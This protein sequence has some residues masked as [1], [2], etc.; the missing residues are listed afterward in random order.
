M[1]QQDKKQSKTVKPFTPQEVE[2]SH[3]MLTR[4]DSLMRQFKTQ[5]GYRINMDGSVSSYAEVMADR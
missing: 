4:Q 1:D 2:R 3:Y 5:G